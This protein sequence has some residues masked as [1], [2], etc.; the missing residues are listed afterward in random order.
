MA[1]AV[2]SR[3][4]LGGVCRGRR[5]G[6]LLAALVGHVKACL[7]SLAI[8]VC[9]DGLASYVKALV[10]AFRHKVQGRV[11]RPRLVEEPGLLIGQVIKRYCG[12][13]LVG[14][15]RRMAWGTVEAVAAVL[16]RTGTGSGIHTAYLERLHATFRASLAGLVRRGRALWHEPEQLQAGVYLVG[17]AYNWCWEHDSLR[18]EVPAESERSGRGERQP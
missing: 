7:L 10:R 5:D 4:W 17:C 9:V 16:T 15:V 11:G 14:V 1:L 3:L 12:R 8:L 13:R 2:P 6:R 18:V